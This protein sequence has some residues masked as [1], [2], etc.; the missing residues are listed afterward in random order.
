LK[1]GERFSSS[2]RKERWGGIFFLTNSRGISVLFLVIAMLLMVTVGYIFSYLIPMKQESVRFP[3][4]SSQAFFIAHSGVEFAIRYSSNQGWRDTTALSG[5]DGMQRN[6]VVGKVNGKFTINYAPDTLTSTGVINNSSE[7]RIITVSNLTQFL[8]VLILDTTDPGTS[9]PCWCYLTRRVRFFIKYVGMNSVT[10]TQFSATWQEGVAKKLTN[11]Y[12]D[13][14]QKY[15]APG[16]EYYNGDPQQNFNSG[17]NSQT[18]NPGQWIPVL[19]YW[20]GDINQTNS[21]IIKFYTALGDPYTFT[22][23]LSPPP[24]GSC[25]VGC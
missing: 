15:N 14:V 6:I 21:I 1:K 3:I 4:Y 24:G 18:I 8:N 11:I 19:V 2:I 7:K 23:N 17:G 5:L 20:N 10:L 25:A 13:G 22:L 16:G 12:M 9:V